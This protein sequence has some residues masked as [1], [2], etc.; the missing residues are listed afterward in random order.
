MRIESTP[1]K[2]DRAKARDESESQVFGTR[3]GLKS[4]Y[5]GFNGKR[6]SKVIFV[7]KVSSL[8]V[9]FDVSCIRSSA[10]TRL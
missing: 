8:F 1:I 5:S 9:R 2:K 10:T 3:S 7:A 6:Y 4:S